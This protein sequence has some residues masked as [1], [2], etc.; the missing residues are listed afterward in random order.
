M[1]YA[2]GYFVVLRISW[3]DLTDEYLFWESSIAHFGKALLDLFYAPVRLIPLQGGLVTYIVL[4]I[5][6]SGFAWLALSLFCLAKR[7]GEGHS[8]EL[9]R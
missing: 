4:F 2:V 9:D 1:I 5:L 3:I 7:L 6:G 8:R